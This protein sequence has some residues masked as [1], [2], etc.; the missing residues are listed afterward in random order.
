MATRTDEDRKLDRETERRVDQLLG[1]QANQPALLEMM[2]RTDQL[3][4]KRAA[5]L[6]TPQEED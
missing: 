1:H 4:L 3:R 6:A 2:Y 5:R